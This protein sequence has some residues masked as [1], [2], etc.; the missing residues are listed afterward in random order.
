MSTLPPSTAALHARLGAAAAIAALLAGCAG[1]T[2]GEHV[3]F[4]AAAAGVQDGADGGVEFDNGPGYH[5]TL[6]RA[7]LH[8]GA[9]YLNQSVP[10]SGSQ[11][12]AC[13]LPGIYVGEVL[14]SL[15]VDVLSS[16]PQPFPVEGDGTTYTAKAGELWLT[17]G[18]INRIEDTTVILDVAGTADRDGM[19]YPFEAK[20]TIGEN[21]LIPSTNPAFPGQNPICKQRIVSPIP[22]DFT[23]HD[24]GRLL[25]RIDPS[26]WFAGVDFSA[27]EQVRED[28]PLYRF[29]DTSSGPAEISLYNGLHA[30]TGAYDFVWK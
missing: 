15:D 19:Q 12:T 13:I 10:S 29:A 5:V 23:L 22:V 28:P 26:V 17:G 8:I 6:T 21:R 1:T 27:L 9:V 20:V 24:G 18:D 30:R 16:T 2:G 7:R 4:H 11:A 25:I 3:H 14:G